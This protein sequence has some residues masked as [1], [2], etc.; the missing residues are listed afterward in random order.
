MEDI[1][2]D[3]RQTTANI[4]EF[5]HVLRSDGSEVVTRLNN[6]VASLNGVVNENRDNLKVTM[7]NVREASKNAELALASIE[8]TA[9]KIDRGEGTLGKLVTDESM[10]NNVDSAA[11][12]IS[13][14]TSHVERL[15][16]TIGFRSEY[17]FPE[18][19]NYF[20]L[21]L[22]PRF[23]QYYI[24]EL[25]SDPFGKFSQTTTTTTPPGTTVVTNTF[26]NKLK[27]SLEF[28]KR[29]GNLAIRMGL[30]ESTGGAGVDYFALDD[31]IKF[32]LEAWNSNS[33]EPGN[34][35]AHVKATLNYNLSKVLYVDAGYD[36]F[37]NGTSA[38]AF[39]GLGLRFSDEDVKYYLGSVPMP[40]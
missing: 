1:L 9:R 30:I 32:S 39:V 21:E 12:G 5:S 33:H 36:N 37:L 31:K 23:D 34:D 24:F 16:T 40:R 22:K 7:E 14:Y 3:L 28:A 19:K 15:K 13:E 35:R 26:E 10:Y 25:V 17:M 8:N 38:H 18:V 2:A 11:K 27:Y 29:F 6:L 4:Q 20:T